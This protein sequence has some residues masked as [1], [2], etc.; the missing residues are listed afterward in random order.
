MKILC[1]I[2]VLYNGETCLKAFK[3]VIQETDLLI[4][5]NGSEI[6][7]KQAIK[8]MWFEYPNVKVIQNERNI[9]VNAAWNQIIDYFLKS[10][11]D[12]LIIMNSDL[13]MTAGWSKH[14]EDNI[15]AIPSDGTH[16]QDEIVFN[17]T[18]GVFIQLN[19]EMAKLVYPIP[20]SILVWFGDL[21]AYTKIRKAGY[22][23]IVKA[24][25]IAQHWHNGSQT[26][27]KLKNFQEIIAQDKLAWL[28]IE[29]TL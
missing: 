6:D 19:K 28:E 4:I 23:T 8:Q 22:R 9:Y 18:P 11:Y 21:W 27:Q 10:H 5:D 17:G 13:I 20:E 24:N 7:V 15:S 25:L 16:K 12:Q 26:C 3:S 1:G 2:P 14:L 29:K